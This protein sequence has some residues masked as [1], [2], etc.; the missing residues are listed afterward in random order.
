MTPSF[1]PPKHAANRLLTLLAPGIA[2]VLLLLMAPPALPQTG[3]PAVVVVD[4]AAANSVEFDLPA[5]RALPMTEF[6]TSTVWT[7]TVD[8]YAGVLLRDLLQEVGVDLAATDGRVVIHALDGY[9]ATFGFDDITPE[10]PLLAFLRNG[11]E[12]PLRAQ[13]PFWILFPFDDNP[14]F[15]TE[16]AYARSVWQVS[17]IVVER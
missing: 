5:L 15:Q 9:T 8:H 10:A 2:A 13:G 11:A 16:T 6:D 1:G 7:E 12:M 17:R 4:A 3:A 14:A